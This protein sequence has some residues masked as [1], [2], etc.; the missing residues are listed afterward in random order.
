MKVSTGLT[1]AHNKRCNSNDEYK[2]MFL[3]EKFFALAT[4]AENYRVGLNFRAI[5]KED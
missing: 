1:A 2:Y 3:N 4:R 5:F